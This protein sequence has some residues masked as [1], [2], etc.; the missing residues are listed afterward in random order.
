MRPNFFAH[1]NNE[2]SQDAVI[3]WLIKWSAVQG[4]DKS[5]QALRDLGHTFVK[6]LLC[7]HCVNMAGA[8]RHTEIHQQ[9]CGIDVLVRIRDENAEHVL[10]I[11]DKTAPA[12]GVYTTGETL[13]RLCDRLQGYCKCL[14]N[15]ETQLGAVREHW[16][17]YLTTANQSLAK[18]H[19]IQRRTGFEIFRRNDFLEVLKS[20]QGT[21]PIVTD[22]RDYLQ[23]LEDGLESYHAWRNGDDRSCWSWAGWEVFYRHLEKKL[24]DQLEGECKSEDGWGNVPTSQGPFLGFWRILPESSFYLQL[25]VHPGDPDRQNICFKVY[26][27][28]NNR[29]SA[30]CFYDLLVDTAQELRLEGLIQ[31]P[32][33][34]GAGYNITFGWFNQWLAYNDDGEL[35]HNKIVNNWQQAWQIIGE[36]NRHFVNSTC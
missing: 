8:V 27:E 9:N 15:E 22:F 11:E 14:R 1:A 4:G 28:K 5:V 31:R 17:V 3:C 29:K 18:D 32:D 6:A 12:P 25:E 33:R 10:L 30:H 24:A 23:R 13:I 34:F 35:D 21:H 2:R 19:T 20:Y 26:Q 36:V 7:K 16:P